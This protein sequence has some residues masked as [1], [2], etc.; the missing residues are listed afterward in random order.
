MDDAKRRALI[1]A[2][3]T[4]KKESGDVA[5]STTVAIN[6]FVKRKSTPKWDR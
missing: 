2:Q 4:K 5:L 1:K 3:P 6:P